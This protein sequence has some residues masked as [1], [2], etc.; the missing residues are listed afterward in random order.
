MGIAPYNY[1]NPQTA[2]PT[3]SGGIKPFVYPT[4][5]APV[6]QP[7]IA[8]KVSGVVSNI[9]TA[10]KNTFT[11]PNPYAPSLYDQAAGKNPVPTYPQQI[12]S[13]FESS[14][15]APAKVPVTPQSY[16]SD[17]YGTGGTNPEGGIAGDTLQAWQK[18]ISDMSAVQNQPTEAGRLVGLGQAGVDALKAFFQPVSTVM[19]EAAT[20]P[21]PTGDMANFVN[22]FF[23]MVGKVGQDTAAA[24]VNG[25]TNLSSSQKA[26]LIP[27][28]QQI[29]AI[30]AQII[31]GKVGADSFDTL[32][33]ATGSFLDTL[34]EDS[35]LKVLNSN[36]DMLAHIEKQTAPNPEVKVPVTS[37]DEGGTVISRPLKLP[38]G[39]T[40]K[41]TIRLPAEQTE[42]PTISLPE[43]NPETD[44]SKLLPEGKPT[45]P[46]QGEGF[47]MADKADAQ[48]VA[49]GKATA[50][51][52]DAVNS[53]SEKPSPAKLAKVQ[54]ARENLKNVREAPVP[55][56]VPVKAPKIAPVKAEIA[57]SAAKPVATEK[58][59][60]APV[61]APPSAKIAPIERPTDESGQRASKAANDINEKLVSQGMDRLSP[62]QMTKYTTGSY[63][64]SEA[65]AKILKEENPDALHEM[66]VTGK[67]I[68][69]GV[70][71]QIL[72]NVAEAHA[73]E[74]FKQTGDSTLQR[75]LATSPLSK[76]LSE[77]ASTMGSH[78]FN[79]NPNSTVKALQRAAEAKT[80]G[81]V[82]AAKIADEAKKAKTVITKTA[83]KIIDYNKI[84]SALTC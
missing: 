38:E 42:N 58:V 53:F 83:T 19:S 49:I 60:P 50:E 43:T 45:I 75:E 13:D 32:K 84:L 81:K 63:K 14:T 71:P 52:K 82:G 23:G 33:T 36:P 15:P 35:R 20:I 12:A 44:S 29:G 25:N 73:D 22:Q 41:P 17:I 5:A 78:G 11:A 55:K 80:G 39:S 48:K 46:I 66:A 31:A 37:G 8:S 51:Y 27:L 65:Q 76:E 72:F 59:A 6:A 4:A 64:D 2:A 54:K 10:I 9:G 77:A 47:T 7:T 56:V 21:G 16:L 62:E 79:D 68:P 3:P 28:A 30:G 26:T 34:G 70:H 69:E 18:T 74:V 1:A 67:G 57:P 61:E 40:G 24:W